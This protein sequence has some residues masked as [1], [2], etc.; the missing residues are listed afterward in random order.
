M[1]ENLKI[2]LVMPCLNEEGGLRIMLPQTPEGLD[3]VVIANNQSTDQSEAVAREFGAVVVQVPQRGYGH[4][5]R[6]GLLAASGD[7]LIT[8][9]ADNTYPM[10]AIPDLVATLVQDDLDF[11]TVSRDGMNPMRSVDALV[12]RMGERVLAMTLAMST[13]VSLTD[14]QSGMW[15]IRRQVLSSILPES[16]SMSFSQEIKIRAHLHPTIKARELS[17]TF[18]NNERP[19]HSKLRLV[20]DGLG[21]LLR[22]WELGGKL[23]KEAHNGSGTPFRT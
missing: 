9:D 15:V 10:S 11:I 17:V 7:V 2:S 12:R 19:G 23:R 18:P 1:M 5:C 3:E 22:A 6:E 8:M 13:G 21:N 4:A 20:E 14:S 16:G